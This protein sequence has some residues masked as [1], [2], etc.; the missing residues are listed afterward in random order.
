MTPAVLVAIT[1]SPT[2]A[3]IA[4]GNTQQFTA[5]GHYS[6]LS[7]QDLTS[8]VTWS[9]SLTSFATISN[10]SGCQGLATGVA[11]G[12]TTITATSGLISGVAALT[13]TPAVLTSIT[14]SPTAATIATGHTQQFTA[15]GHYSDLSTKDLT[16]SVTW[17]SSTTSVATVSN[18]TGSKGLALGVGPGSSQIKATDA[19]SGKQAAAD[20][21][22]VAP[23]MLTITPSSGPASTAVQIK[24]VG[25][26]AGVA[27]KIKYQVGTRWHRLCLV[28]V[29]T[30]GSFLCNSTI[31][32]A[33]RAGALG[34][35][36]ILAKG[37]AWRNHTATTTFTLVAGA[38]GVTAQLLAPVNSV[39][40]PAPQIRRDRIHQSGQPPR[41]LRKD[42]SQKAALP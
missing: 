18:T 15:T 20:L 24:G 4:A 34:P 12:A 3:S 13:V 26:P 23:T 28:T 8:S 25:F 30:N 31:P 6:D 33:S 1:V 17:S 32:R 9:S 42:R 21:T 39:S 2:I 27:L 11:T 29:A 37:K 40:V 14:V 19:G 7:T 41:R 5:T 10:A 38:A 36:T 16:A 35:H 22:V